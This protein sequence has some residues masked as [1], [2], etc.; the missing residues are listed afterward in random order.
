MSRTRIDFPKCIQLVV[1]DINFHGLKN[2]VLENIN[3]HAQ[4]PQ[5]MLSNGT[6]FFNIFFFASSK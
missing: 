3:F 5:E 6:H 1:E 2:D 4:D